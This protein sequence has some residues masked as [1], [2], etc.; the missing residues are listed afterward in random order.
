L[1]FFFR[2][3]KVSIRFDHTN[4][5]SGIETF[6]KFVTYVLSNNCEDKLFRNDAID[7]VCNIFQ[8]LFIF[9]YYTNNNL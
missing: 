8:N 5:V 4:F 3:E 9:F 6:F 7:E 1:H 2:L